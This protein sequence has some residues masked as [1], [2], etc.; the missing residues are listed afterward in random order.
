MSR[1]RHLP[2][3]FAGEGR[4]LAETAFANAQL[5]QPSTHEPDKPKADLQ[6][7]A[8]A[9]FCQAIFAL[10]EFIYVD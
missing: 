10:N 4:P 8:L 1:L 3:R 6:N 9:D 7:F 5:Q 2:E